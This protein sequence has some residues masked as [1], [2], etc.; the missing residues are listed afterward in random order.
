MPWTTLVSER[1]STEMNQ[2]RLLKSHSLTRMDGSLKNSRRE[3][4]L[5]PPKNMI[6]LKR[7]TP[8]STKKSLLIANS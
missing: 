1:N 8:R 3:D 7:S 6:S 4:P 2:L 5:L